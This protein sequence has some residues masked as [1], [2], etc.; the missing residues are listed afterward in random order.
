MK[1]LILM[2]L[3]AAVAF[4]GLAKP[5]ISPENGRLWQTVFSPED[6]LE[7]RWEQESA[8]ATVTVSNLVTGVVSVSAP[9]VRS[10]GARNGSYAMPSLDGADNG[11]ALVDVVLEQKDGDSAVLATS[12]ARLAFLP[13]TDG[14]T[15]DLDLRDKPKGDGVRVVAFDGCWVNDQ[16]STSAEASFV[17]GENPPEVWALEGGS[18]YFP[19]AVKDG[20][21]SVSF[22]GQANALSGP[23]Y[24]TTG[25]IML[26]K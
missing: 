21:L 26:F 3:V 25:F 20:L 6:P 11:E 15:F 16:P 2:G 22:P 17:A 19:L 4:A 8:S 12:R 18:G 24:L 7:W 9:V 1:H 23:V 13:G 5:V 14:G 10:A